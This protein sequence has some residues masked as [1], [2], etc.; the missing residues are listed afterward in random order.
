MILILN[1]QSAWLYPSILT[2]N[3]KMDYP[4]QIACVQPS[5]P[6]RKHRRRGFCGGGGR[7]YTGHSQTDNPFLA[8]GWKRPTTKC[9]CPVFLM[10]GKDCTER[11]SAVALSVGLIIPRGICVSGHV[12]ERVFISQ[13]RHRNTLTEIAWEAEV[14]GLSIAMSTVTSEKKRELL[15][16][17]NVFYKLPHSN[18]LIAM[19]EL[20]NLRQGKIYCETENPC[21]ES[22]LCGRA[23]W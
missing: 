21:E 5:P 13:I 18:E 8:L 16:T 7:L 17:G 14:Q 23:Q 9:L 22:Q 19:W 11:L 1:E 10:I 4:F 2:G 6:L 15:F 12:S 3:L 20:H